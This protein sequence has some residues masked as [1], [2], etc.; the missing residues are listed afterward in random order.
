[1]EKREQENF[2]KVIERYAEEKQQ[3]KLLEESAKEKN[4]F[5]KNKIQELD[6][7]LYQTDKYK[8]SIQHSNRISMDEEK[9]IGIIKENIPEDKRNGVIKTKE[10]VDFDILENLVYNSIIAAEK[11]EPAQI[12]KVTDSLFVKPVKTKKEEVNE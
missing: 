11:L 7:D 10:Y 4:V 8:V 9:L 12:I 6:T 2:E 1:M 3:M 5:I